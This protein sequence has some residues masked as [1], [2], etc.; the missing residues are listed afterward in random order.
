MAHISRKGD[1]VLPEIRFKI[2]GTEVDAPENWKDLEIVR[3]RDDKIEGWYT[4]FSSVL[5]FSGN[6][7]TAIKAAVDSDL[8]DNLTILVE[9]RCSRFESWS[10]LVDGV[11]VT[12][13]VE[14]T[15]A[16]PCL[17]R[18]TIEQNACVNQFLDNFDKPFDFSYETTISGTSVLTVPTEQINDMLEAPS[19]DSA[20]SEGWPDSY[21]A[22]LFDVL[23]NMIQYYTDDCMQLDS[24]YLSTVYQPCI[25]RFDVTTAPANGDTISLEV[26]DDR[27]ARF[28]FSLEVDASWITRWRQVILLSDNDDKPSLYITVPYAATHTTTGTPSEQFDIEFYH[29]VDIISSSF[30]TGA[31]TVTKIQNYT[32]GGNGI[33]IG[34][35]LSLINSRPDSP[36][37]LRTSFNKLFFQVRRLLDVGLQIK[38]VGG[39][40]KISIEPIE[41]ILSTATPLTIRGVEN[42]FYEY[43]TDLIGNQVVLGNESES[44]PDYSGASGADPVEN[45]EEDFSLNPNECGVINRVVDKEYWA[46]MADK[47]KP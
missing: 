13:D 5:E 45:T 37:T 33:F 17:A 19:G 34:N 36:G 16:S 43:D 41:D 39:N 12:K 8:C 29:N 1:A 23:D 20:A 7:Y 10:T 22:R 42:V 15:E 35:G 28:S 2:D 46:L 21:G 6:G 32:R 24:T 26:E 31:G 47:I 27:G 4:L 11:I 30:G 44:L 9:S 38:E 14:F 3:K 40:W 25:I 18:V